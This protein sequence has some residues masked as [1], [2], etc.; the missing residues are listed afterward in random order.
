MSKTEFLQKLSNMTREQ[1]QEELIKK[2][3]PA[4]KIPIMFFIEK[5]KVKSKQ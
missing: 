1:I 4:K 2:S 3:K 5:K